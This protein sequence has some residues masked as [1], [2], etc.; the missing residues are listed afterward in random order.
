MGHFKILVVLDSRTFHKYFAPDRVEMSS[1]NGGMAEGD[2]GGEAEGNI[3]GR[4]VASAGNTSESSH[5]KDVS[6]PDVPSRDDSIEFIGIIRKEMRRI[7]PHV[8]DLDL[9]RWLGSQSDSR[10]SPKLRSDAMSKRIKLSELA[11][12]VAKKTATSSSKGVMIYEASKTASKNRA[13][14]DRFKGK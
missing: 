2:I 9:L 13:L 6:R 5:S 8:P 7:F 3:G 4:A 14:D 10:V 12:V 1:S 11:K